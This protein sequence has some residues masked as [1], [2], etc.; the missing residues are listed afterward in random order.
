MGIVSVLLL[1]LFSVTSVLL[2]LIVMLQDEQG[3]GLG[4]IFGGGGASGQ[5]GNRKG[6]ILTRTTT[7]LGVV[8]V[9]TSFGLAWLNRTPDLGNPGA[10]QGDNTE[11]FEAWWNQLPQADDSSTQTGN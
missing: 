7:V 8:F 10:I 2:I 11:E 6:N 3:E 5:I 1:V 9:L 4:G